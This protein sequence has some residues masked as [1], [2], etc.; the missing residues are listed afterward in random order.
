MQGTCLLAHLR[1][2]ETLPME[3]ALQRQTGQMRLDEGYLCGQQ[4]NQEYQHKP[5]VGTGP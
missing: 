5:E 4:T 1:V 3:S 2:T